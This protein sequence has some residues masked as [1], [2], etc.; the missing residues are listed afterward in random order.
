MKI[1]LKLIKT[2][3]IEFIDKKIKKKKIKI[4]LNDTKLDL[5][6]NELIDSIDFLDLLSSIEKKFKVEIDLSEIKAKNFSKINSLSKSIYE[7]LK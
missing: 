7:N 1:T 5:L 4:N 3:I 2:D 6:K